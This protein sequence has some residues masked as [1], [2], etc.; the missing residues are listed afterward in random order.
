[1]ECGDLGCYAH[2]DNLLSQSARFYLPREAATSMLEQMEQQIA[3]TW[4]ETARRE[5]VIERCCEKIAGAFID[6]GFRLVRDE[7]Q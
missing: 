6:P 2:A 3:A 7:R 1:M 4:Y 5:G